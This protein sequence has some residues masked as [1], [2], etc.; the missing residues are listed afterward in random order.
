MQNL[1]WRRKLWLAWTN[2]ASFEVVIRSTLSLG[3]VVTKKSR[4]KSQKLRVG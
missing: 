2:T 3:V 4:L 1:S